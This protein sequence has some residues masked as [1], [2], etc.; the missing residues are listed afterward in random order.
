MDMSKFFYR[1]ALTALRHAFLKR[2]RVPYTEQDLFVLVHSYEDFVDLQDI[3]PWATHRQL[4][5]LHGGKRLKIPTIAQ[6]EREMENYKLHQ[7]IDETDLDPA[8][9]ATVATKRKKTAKSASQAYEEMSAI[10]NPRRAGEH[11]IFGHE[12][13]HDDAH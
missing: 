5:V 8:S 13:E 1:W 12:N 6:W 2:I 4:M 9:I 11:Y 10:L 7:E 3:M